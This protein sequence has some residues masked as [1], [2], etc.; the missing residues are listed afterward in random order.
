MAVEQCF[1]SGLCNYNSLVED[2]LWKV[3]NN[4]A[5]EDFSSFFFLIL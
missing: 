5:G 3:N 1:D 2:L 4:S